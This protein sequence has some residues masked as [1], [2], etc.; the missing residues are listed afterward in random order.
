[1]KNFI[2][3]LVGIFLSV[4]FAEAQVKIG[5]NT[6]TVDNRS[7]LEL[8]ADNLGMWLTR[9]TTVQRNAVSNWRAGH[10]IFNI[11]D[12]CFQF[13][14]GNK[15][16]CIISTHQSNRALV[17]PRRDAT[18]IGNLTN[19]TNGTV[20]YNTTEKCLQFFVDD[21]WICIDDAALNQSTGGGA[22]FDLLGNCGCADAVGVTGGSS[23][24]PFDL[25]STMNNYCGILLQ[26]GASNSF[27]YYRLPDPANYKGKYFCF[28][29]NFSGTSFTT[30]YLATPAVTGNR[31]VSLHWNRSILGTG[32]LAACQL[33]DPARSNMIVARVFSNGTY[34]FVAAGY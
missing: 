10:L 22:K 4:F 24:S 33:Q 17:M 11:T 1:M 14:D 18:T 15:W 7:I 16:E 13:Y 28:R 6:N 20:V 3:T 8:E 19:V 9:L 31:V 25:T 26:N 23:G 12:S 32:V 30:A 29:T 34:W 5:G 2:L 27:A 21:E